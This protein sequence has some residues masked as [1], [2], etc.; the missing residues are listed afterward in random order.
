M[1]TEHL[2]PVLNDA[3]TTNLFFRVGE[4]L[5]RGD[6]PQ[7]V[8]QMVRQGRMTALAKLDGGVRGIVAGDVIRRL[9]AKTMAQQLGDAVEAFTAPY[10]YAL[11]TKAGCE[12][13]AHVLQ[14]LTE[15]DPLATVTSV[16]GISK[17]DLIS[18]KA[19]LVELMRVDGGSSALPFVR[20]FYGSPSEYLWEGRHRARCTQFPRGEGGEQGDPLMP[21][22]FLSRAALISGSCWSPN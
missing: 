19:M 4:K 16:D 2:R 3:H 20:L 14:G 21:A 10:Q 18:R 12:C 8:V 6:V 22:S 7:S 5:S 17:F 11:R 1:T 15:L 9:V 13:V